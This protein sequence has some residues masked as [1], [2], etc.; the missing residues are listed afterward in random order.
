MSRHKNRKRRQKPVRAGSLGQAHAKC[1][2][3]TIVEGEHKGMFF[4]LYGL[5][6][7]DVAE[8]RAACAEGR[9]NEGAFLVVYGLFQVLGL[10]FTVPEWP[11][12]EV[13]DLFAMVGLP[14][15]VWPCDVDA[16]LARLLSEVAS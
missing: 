16:E 12:D 13:L 9:V 7:Q 15:G 11:M 10:D 3:I 2:N 1:T 14:V 4:T 5:D 8:A 6:D